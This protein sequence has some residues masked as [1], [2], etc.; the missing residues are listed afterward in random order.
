M[1]RR[2]CLKGASMDEIDAAVWG[3]RIVSD[4]ALSSRMNSMRHAIGRVLIARP[5]VGAAR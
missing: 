1:L 4:A 2:E 3:G 5:E